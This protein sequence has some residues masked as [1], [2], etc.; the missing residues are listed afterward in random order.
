[1]PQDT[2]AAAIAACD[3]VLMDPISAEFL[4]FSRKTLVEECWPRLQSAVATLPND[5]LWWRPNEA[6]NSI[7]NL[8]LHLNG[9]MRQWLIEGVGG[10]RYERHRG[11][12][13]AEREQVPVTALMSTLGETIALA[14]EVLQGVTADQLAAN[15]TI[16]GHQTT[17][18]AA[19]YHV[20]EHFT[21]HYGQIL[22][23]TKLVAGRDLGFYAHLNEPGA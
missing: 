10:V 18:L 22:Y 9:N 6:S 23:I 13:F 11:R 4:A 1:M 3:A 17:T 5:R 20:I 15:K 19:I 7:G 12:E 14:D 21:M 16:Q 2:I 8:L